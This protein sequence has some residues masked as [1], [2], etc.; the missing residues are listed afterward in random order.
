MLLAEVRLQWA[1]RTL[2][3][4][5]PGV[6]SWAPSR[7]LEVESGLLQEEVIEVAG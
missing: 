1:Q 3:E 5:W 6:D 7:F 4:H 2:E